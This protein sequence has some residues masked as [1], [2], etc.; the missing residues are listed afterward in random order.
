VDN[1]LAWRGYSARRGLAAT[2]RA[3]WLLS[4]ADEDSALAWERD[5]ASRLGPLPLTLLEP[6]QRPAV[7]ALR[8]AG[9]HTFGDIL[10][11]PPAALGRRCGESFS[12]L[13][14]QILGQETDLQPTFQPPASFSDEYWF[15]YEVKANAELLPAM[16]VLLQSLCRFL[17]NTQLHTDT[18]RWQ[19][20]GVDR[21]LHDLTVRSESSGAHWESWYQLSRL[22]LDRLAL[23]TGI[24]GLLL[25]CD[26]LRPGAAET[27]DLFRTAGQREPLG[28]LL[29]RLRSRLGL[30]AVTRVSCRDE[31]LP[32][33]AVHEGM[34]VSTGGDPPGHCAQ[35]PFWL[36]PRPQP[37]QG[38]G[39]HLAWHGPLTLVYGPE[40]I[41]DNWWQEPAS[42]DYYVAAD[43]SGHC[44][45]VFRDRMAQRWYIHGIFA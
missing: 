21:R 35:R 18:I 36:M 10:T 1:G 14:R 8:R 20:G 12:R 34:D 5:L 32:E 15:G 7:Q 29:D 6:E 11:L 30:Q 3:A 27:A 41:E 45:W 16:Q 25:H 42:R 28:S 26:Q 24:E 19:L 9:L 38:A 43:G 33:F 31:H 37:M 22:H 4:H 17:G 40:R 23:R 39:D 2:A 13:L 44:Y